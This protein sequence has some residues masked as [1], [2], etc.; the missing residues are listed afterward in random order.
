M[1]RIVDPSSVYFQAVLSESQ[2]GAVKIGQPVDVSIDALPETATR[3]IAGRVSRLLPVAS[4]ARSFSVRIDLPIDNRMRPQM[5]ARGRV[6]AD[7]HRNTTLVPKD[8]VL[9]EPGTGKARVFVAKNNKAE[10]REVRVGLTNPKLVEI[11]NGAVTPNDKVIVAGQ[12]S[13]QDG[14]PIRTK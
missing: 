4:S 13:L 10:E 9:F 2:Y 14:D 3:P 7:V 12:I 1:L 6:L 11:T 5:F 8:A